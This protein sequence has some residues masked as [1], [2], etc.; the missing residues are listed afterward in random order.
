MRMVD[1][2]MLSA[3]RR[4]MIGFGAIYIWEMHG[5]I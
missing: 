5:G 4:C 1:I 2:E 3:Y